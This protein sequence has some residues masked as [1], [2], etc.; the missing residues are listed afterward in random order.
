MVDEEPNFVD[1]ACL[2]KITPEAI[3]D[4][5]GGQ[6]NASFFEAANI[7]GT[8]KQ[9]G[10]VEFKSSYPG[11]NTITVTDL[12]KELIA[13]AESKSMEPMDVLDNNILNQLSGG[14]REPKE[15]SNS[16]NLRPK[17]LALR[18]Y[19]LNKTGLLVY[20]LKNGLAEISLTEAGYLKVKSE[21]AQASADAAKPQDAPASADAAK[22]QSGPAVQ[23]PIDPPKN[24]MPLTGVIVIEVLIIALIIVG[25]YLKH[26]I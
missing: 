6:I 13:E 4:K 10:L 5:F 9:K 25:L 12:G 3:L 21:P 20:E 22:S 2:I 7:A 1:L 14:K 17:D 11:P 18:I 26:I 16:L 24:K 23:D 8:M 19:K 15:M